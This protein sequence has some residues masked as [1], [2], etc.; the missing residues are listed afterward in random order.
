MMSFI[1]IIQAETAESLNG[2]DIKKFVE[3]NDASFIKY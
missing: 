2:E 1:Q 3:N